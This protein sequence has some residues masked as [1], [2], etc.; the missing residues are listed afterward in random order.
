MIL[1]GRAERP[2]EGV[3][4][5][6]VIVAVVNARAVVAVA[7]LAIAV[8]AVTIVPVIPIVAEIARLHV[9]LDR[10]RACTRTVASDA[11]A[12]GKPRLGE[13]RTSSHQRYCQ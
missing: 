1:T 13:H 9:V 4:A 3:L 11:D 7:F 10:R 6:E 2:V 12:D 8:I 5:A